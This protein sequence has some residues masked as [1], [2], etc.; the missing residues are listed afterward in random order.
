M[1][2]AYGCA[3]GG[4]GVDQGASNTGIWLWPE[5]SR[6]G[7]GCGHGRRRFKIPTSQARTGAK[8]VPTLAV[9][10]GQQSFRLLRSNA[11]RARPRRGEDE[12]EV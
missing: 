8:K 2:G 10:V 5:D 1:C 3:C 7:G 11:R 4:G 9:A 6:G 12:L